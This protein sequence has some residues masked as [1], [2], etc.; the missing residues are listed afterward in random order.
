MLITYLIIGAICAGAVLA[1]A[2]TVSYFMSLYDMKRE[3][4]NRDTNSA[5]KATVEDVIGSSLSSAKTVKVGLF[6]N[7]DKVAEAT[8]ECSAGTS[9]K[10]GD[11]IYI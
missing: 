10:K 2:F 5:T 9:V 6:S 7:G 8:I 4:N 3:L 11:Y 1:I